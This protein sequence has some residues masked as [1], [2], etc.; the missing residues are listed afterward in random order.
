MS[1]TYTKFQLPA[2][3]ALPEGGYA[4]ICDRQSALAREHDALVKHLSSSSLQPYYSIHFTATGEAIGGRTLTEGE[5]EA[6]IRMAR[7]RGLRV[8]E[9]AADQQTAQDL[10]GDWTL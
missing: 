4:I 7:D 1:T 2:S 9:L 6:A 8:E 3:A 5:R 10:E